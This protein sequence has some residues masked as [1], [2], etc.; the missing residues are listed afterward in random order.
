MSDYANAAAYAAFGYLPADASDLP[1]FPECE[2]EGYA[3]PV[4]PSADW[5]R[6]RTGILSRRDTIEAKRRDRA[7]ARGFIDG[8][9][10]LKADR[11][12]RA[13]GVPGFGTLHHDQ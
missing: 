5:V 12:T 2:G 7:Y 1:P 11:D 6:T 8:S 4:A 13:R 9:P 3:G 10:A